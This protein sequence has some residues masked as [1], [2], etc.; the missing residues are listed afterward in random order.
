MTHLLG[1]VQ[2]WDTAD[3]VEAGVTVCLDGEN[4]LLKAERLMFFG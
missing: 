3:I 1:L 4:Q 2:D